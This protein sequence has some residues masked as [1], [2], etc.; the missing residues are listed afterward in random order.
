MSMMTS[1]AIWAVGA[2]TVLV[3]V[4]AWTLVRIN[5]IPPSRR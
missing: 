5:D 3:N 4:L 2:M 1:W